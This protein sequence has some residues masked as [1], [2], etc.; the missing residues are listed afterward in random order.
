MAA[1]RSKTVVIGVTGSIAC[2]KACEVVSALRKLPGAEVRVVMTRDATRFVSPMTFQTLSGH[3]V[4]HDL[5]DAPE[6]WDLLHTSLAAAAAVVAICPATM[7]IL[8][9]LAHGLCD[10]LVTGVV[11]ATKAPVLLVPAMHREMYAHPTTRRNLA[12]LKQCGYECVGPVHGALACGVV[13]MG[14]MAEPETV[15]QA[16][17]RTL[18]R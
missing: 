3:P 5:F 14:H 8:G 16:I 4:Y 7:N 12:A 2:Y 6:E 10:D 17:R 1:P 18:A 13:G 11:F 9:K 15:V